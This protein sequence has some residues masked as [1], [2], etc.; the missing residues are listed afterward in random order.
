ML[1]LL[2]ID[3]KIK[4]NKKFFYME[5][6]DGPVVGFQNSPSIWYTGGTMSCRK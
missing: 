5:N 3:E 6:E 2:T 1:K 4:N